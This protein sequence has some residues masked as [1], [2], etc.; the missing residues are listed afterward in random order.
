MDLLW[1]YQEGYIPEKMFVLP[2][3]GNP[4]NH[5]WENL[6]LSMERMLP[7]NNSS[8]YIGLSPVGRK[9]RLRRFVDGKDIHVGM[10]ETL[11]EGIEAIGG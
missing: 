5:K 3:D 8:G 10:F 2:L 7:V 9:W 4:Q 6:T 1:I 11:E